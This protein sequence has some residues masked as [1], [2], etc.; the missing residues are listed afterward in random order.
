MSRTKKEYIYAVWTNSSTFLITTQT[1]SLALSFY[2][3][4]ITWKEE[5]K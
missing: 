3:K 1:Y 5:N 2:S 4:F